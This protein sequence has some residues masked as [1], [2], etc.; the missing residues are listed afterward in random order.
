MP[1]FSVTRTYSSQACMARSRDSRTLMPPNS[2]NGLS[3]AI[4]ISPTLMIFWVMSF[5][6]CLAGLLQR[7]LD[8][9]AEQ[10]VAITR[11]GGEFRVELAGDEPRM[12]RSLDHFNQ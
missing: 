2:T 4:S 1:S 11:G 5:A 7:G 6:L 3:L 8:E 9:A 10:R 12:I